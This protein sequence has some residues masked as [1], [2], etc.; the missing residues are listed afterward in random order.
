MRQPTH[1]IKRHPQP[2]QTFLPNRHVATR[3]QVRVYDRQDSFERDVQRLHQRGWKLY[4]S[5]HLRSCIPIELTRASARGLAPQASADR[6]EARF[7]CR[8]TSSPATATFAWRWLEQ[9][10]VHLRRE[11]G[12]SIVRLGTLVAGQSNQAEASHACIDTTCG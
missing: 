8:S 11:L 7:V 1:G 5:D 4:S 12:E 6:I 2:A 10:Y 9:P 3:I